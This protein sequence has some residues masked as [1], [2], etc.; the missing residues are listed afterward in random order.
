MIS[1]LTITYNKLPPS[2]PPGDLVFRELQADL[3]DKPFYKGGR[4][5]ANSPM[6]ANY[7]GFDRVIATYDGD[8]PTSSEL[9]ALKDS[10][11]VSEVVKNAYTKSMIVFCMNFQNQEAAVTLL[12]TIPS[13]KVAMLDVRVSQYGLPN[14]GRMKRQIED[15]TGREAARYSVV[16]KIIGHDGF[17]DGSLFLCCRVWHDH[18]PGKKKKYTEKCLKMIICAIN[19]KLRS[20]VR[21]CGDDCSP[22]VLRGKIS[23]CLSSFPPTKPLHTIIQELPNPPHLQIIIFQ[24]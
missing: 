20:S 16:E 13:V 8:G 1:C 3:P 6:V 10:S 22:L 23:S 24:Q 18:H 14:Y 2:F 21:V 7:D 12:Y 5:I 19:H 17:V 11:A 4:A 9:Q 15:F